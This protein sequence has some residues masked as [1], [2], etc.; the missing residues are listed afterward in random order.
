MKHIASLLLIFLFVAFG[1]S[2]QTVDMADGLRSSG[3]IY[4]VVIIVMIVLVGLIVY[5]FS[6]DRKLS[7]MERT[8]QERQKTKGRH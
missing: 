2:A 8:I 5:L 3:K 6:M 1:A 7:K 4:I